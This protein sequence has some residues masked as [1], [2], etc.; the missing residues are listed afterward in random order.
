VKTKNVGISLFFETDI[1]S[2]LKNASDK[3]FKLSID[4]K[5]KCWNIKLKEKWSKDEIYTLLNFF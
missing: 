4:F 3:K 1:Q 5:L 2:F